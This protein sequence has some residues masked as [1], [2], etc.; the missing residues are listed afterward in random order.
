MQ[1]G[2]AREGR[3]EAPGGPGL[4][5]RLVKACPIRPGTPMKPML[6][7]T[8]MKPMLKVMLAVVVVG[9]WS[10][11]ASAQVSKAD[12]EIKK[13]RELGGELGKLQ[14]RIV[15]D[16]TAIERTT[17]DLSEASKSA[18]VTLK[19]LFEQLASEASG[20]HEAR[21]K[22]L[23]K[24]A[25]HLANELS[26]VSARCDKVINLLKT[27]RKERGE[28][29]THLKGAIA[30]AGAGGILRANEWGDLKTKSEVTLKWLR[31]SLKEAQNL[32][33][34]SAKPWEELTAAKKKIETTM[35]EKS[36]EFWRLHEVL[37]ECETS[38]A[39]ASRKCS[40]A[41]AAFEVVRKDRGSPS[42]T[43]AIQKR[44]VAEKE[45]QDAIKRT[46]DALANEVKALAEYHARRVEL[47]KLMEDFGK[48]AEKANPVTLDKR[49]NDFDRWTKELEKDLK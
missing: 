26:D 47:T 41:A 9:L 35:N 49:V 36:K 42:F 43:I 13:V 8:P 3:E 14:D 40:E 30:A 24:D 22:D 20:E 34:G 48:L 10:S 23:S 12:S 39:V 32:R 18:S 2:Q 5:V 16:E 7:V 38:E 28:G 44:T 31:E 11:A 27:P 17:K 33:D 25:K 15:L 46:S 37:K 21:L 4:T 19:K 6:K 45:H 29:D 1:E